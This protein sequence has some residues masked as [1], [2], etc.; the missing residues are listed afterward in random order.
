[1]DG[2]VIKANADGKWYKINHVAGVGTLTIFGSYQEA[3]GAGIAYT[4]EPTA[5]W[6]G[7]GSG[8]YSTNPKTTLGVIMQS[9]QSIQRNPIVGTFSVVVNGD[10]WGAVF[11]I[12]TWQW[13][14]LYDETGSMT[15][16][17][18][19]WVFLFP[20][21]AMGMLSVILLIYQMIFGAMSWG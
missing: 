15:M 4:M 1:M 20:F 13:S 8:G 17:I 11:K 19:Y 6:V 21:V 2:G 12:I 3:G 5:G 9:W 18:F 14:F 16:G 10:M 7:V